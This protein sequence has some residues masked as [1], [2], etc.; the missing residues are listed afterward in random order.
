MGSHVKSECSRY[1]GDALA[2]GALLRGEEAKWN[3][4]NWRKTSGKCGRV[5]YEI[6]ESLLS[7][8][9]INMKREDLSTWEI[10]P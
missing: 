5:V 7:F 4:Q 6:C 1:L 2:P 9:K 10:L 3:V 8:E